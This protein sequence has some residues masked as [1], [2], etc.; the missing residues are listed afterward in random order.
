METID[1]TVISALKFLS[2][3][4]NDIKKAGTELQTQLKHLKTI[5][6][7]AGSGNALVTAKILFKNQK[8][9]FASE[10]DFDEKFKTIRPKDVVIV[11]ASGTRDA[12]SMFKQ[13]KKANANVLLITNTKNSPLEKEAKD[14]PN[15]KKILF[16]AIKEPPTYNVST[17]LG[18]IISQTQ[19]NPNQILDF[20]DKLEQKIN[21]SILKENNKFFF[22]FPN[23]FV[24]LTEM[25]YTKMHELFGR[26]I[27]FA[28][29]TPKSMRHGID[30]LISDELFV[31]LG[32]KPNKFTKSQKTFHI[33]LPPKTNYAIAMAVLYYIMGKLQNMYPF[34]GDKFAN[35]NQNAFIT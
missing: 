7:V 20:I 15:F 11:S 23:Q 4:R 26:Q 33:P 8:A 22:V 6:L 21:F 12:M 16:P 29:E 5:P 14:Y 24:Y 18:M 31:F 3:K 9:F 34:F 10:S 25:A 28:A 35:Q 13:A 17:Y 2:E 32:D 19:E 30:N 27:S 1:K